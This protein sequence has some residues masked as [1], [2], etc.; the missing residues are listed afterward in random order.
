MILAWPKRGVHLP[1]DVTLRWLGGRVWSKVDRDNVFGRAAELAYFFLFS[2]FPLLIVLTSLL[3]ALAS[4]EQFLRSLLDYFAAIMPKS[5]YDLVAS[6]LDEIRQSGSGGRL[7]LGI[8]VT[9]A[10]ASSGMVAVIEGLNTAYEVTE[11][12]PWLRRR[13]LAIVLTLALALATISALAIFF[14]GNQLGAWAANHVGFGPAFESAWPFLQWPLAA[15]FLLVAF[16]LIYRF[17]PNVRAQRWR[18]VLP[19]ALAGFLLWLLA[20]LGL[21]IYLHYF[22]TYSAV[23]GS[24]GAVMTLMVWFYLCSIAILV[25]GEINS[26]LENAAAEA[27]DP[28]AKLSGE[29]APGERDY[30]R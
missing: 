28:E 2:I 29:T 9:I 21:R 13:T 25:G 22:D 3:G 1:A 4:G 16:A 23:Y 30:V 24:L 10:S 6:T 20:T 11:A 18:W 12:R 26:V 15:A 5:A 7:S 8:V 19:G 27:G 17:A 14:Y